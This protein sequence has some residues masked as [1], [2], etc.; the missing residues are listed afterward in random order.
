M[1]SVY[2][3]KQKNDAGKSLSSLRKWILL[4]PWLVIL[5]LR[6]PLRRSIESALLC[7]D[8]HE[9]HKKDLSPNR[10]LLGNFKPT[11]GKV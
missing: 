11:R 10:Y 7:T 3:R 6:S 5:R 2:P 8:L 9:P 4:L 1:E